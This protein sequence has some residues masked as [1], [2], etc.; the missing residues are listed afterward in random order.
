MVLTLYPQRRHSISRSYRA[1]VS[2]ALAQRL[3]RHLLPG[4]PDLDS[5]GC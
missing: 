4:C 2:E 5:F 1:V 3:G